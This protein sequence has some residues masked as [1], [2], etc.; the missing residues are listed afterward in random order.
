MR[1]QHATGHIVQS[2][3][4]MLE[5]YRGGQVFKFV[6][7]LHGGGR[8]GQGRSGGIPHHRHC[9]LQDTF[10]GA[11]GGG[12]CRASQHALQAQ[13]KAEHRAADL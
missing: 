8:A 10:A 13:H 5:G 11:Q 6:Q 3:E 12:I 4:K 2:N 7:Q 9:A 1:P